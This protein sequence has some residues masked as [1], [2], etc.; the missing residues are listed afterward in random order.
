MLPSA[1]RV[2]RTLGQRLRAMHGPAAIEVDVLDRQLDRAH[3]GVTAA[4]DEAVVLEA[5]FATTRADLRAALAD[6]VITDAE[7]RRLH[8]DLA[9]GT[10]HASAHTSTLKAL[11]T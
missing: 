1:L 4:A 3:V 5:D 9:A 6:G 7:A 8:R 2:L 11:T 10:R